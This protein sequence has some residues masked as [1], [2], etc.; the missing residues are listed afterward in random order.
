MWKE[1]SIVFER[2]AGG[3]PHWIWK[4]ELGVRLG[5]GLYFNQPSPRNALARHQSMPGSN[6]P[7]GASNLALDQFAP[8][9]S[10]SPISAVRHYHCTA[11]LLLRLILSFLSTHRRQ[12]GSLHHHIRRADDSHSFSIRRLFFLCSLA[13]L[14]LSAIDTFTRSFKHN[15]QAPFDSSIIYCHVLLSCAGNP[16]SPRHCCTRS[17]VNL[18]SILRHFEFKDG[19]FPQTLSRDDGQTRPGP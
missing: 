18:I 2:V 15:T 14:L 11:S 5:L 19:P 13:V 12:S 3:S 16:N 7:S 10:S 9:S 17:K 6:S 4:A 8:P 1:R